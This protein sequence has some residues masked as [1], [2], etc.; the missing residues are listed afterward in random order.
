MNPH[1]HRHKKQSF[2]KVMR[3]IGH[4]LKPF[5]KSLIKAIELPTHAVDALAKS[6]QSLVLPIAIIGGIILVVYLNK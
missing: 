4:G 1:H 5:E 6:S 3:Q 2:A